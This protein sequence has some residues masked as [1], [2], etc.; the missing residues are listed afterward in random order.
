MSKVDLIV[1]GQHVKVSPGMA[2]ILVE[3]GK[4][5]EEKM[6]RMEEFFRKWL[7]DGGLERL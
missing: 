6:K 3:L 2:K 7:A 5:H 1:D 4:M